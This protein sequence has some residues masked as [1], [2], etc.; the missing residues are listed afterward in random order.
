MSA[1][2]AA[3]LAYAQRLNWPV[4][5]IHSVNTAG[6]C[7]CAKADCK[8]PGKHPMGH[9]APNGLKD[10]TLD[11]D[12]ITRWWS[13]MPNANIGIVT[14]AVSEL[15]VLDV[16][17]QKYGEDSLYTLTQEFGPLPETVVALTGGGGAH[18]LFQHP[19][20]GI[21]VRNSVENL[22]PGLDIRGD[23]GYI[24]VSPSRHAS[25]RTY[26]WE[27]SCRPLEVPVAPLPDWLLARII[28]HPRP[29]PAPAVG[30][31]GSGK[32]YPGEI[33]RLKAA[34]TFLDPDAYDVWIQTGM[35]LH[36]SGDD[37]RAFELWT[38]WAAQS[39]KFDL[40][41][42]QRRWAGFSR[43]GNGVGLGT[44]FAS[45]KAAGYAPPTPPPYEPP[46][47]PPTPPGGDYAGGSGADWERCLRR[48]GKGRVESTAGNIETIL[49]NHELWAG[50]L[51]YDEMSYST[52]K[53]RP[54]PYAG[55]KAGEWTDADDIWTAIWLE[56]HYDVCPRPT[57]VGQVVAATAQ[58]TPF[59]QVRRWLE[60]LTPWDGIDRLPRF[61]VDA[62]G[63]TLS[64]YVEA[65]GRAF[66]V[67]AVARV[68][69]PGVKVDT[70][71]TLE[72]K[73]GVGK[74]KLILELFSPT[75]HIEISY[76][77][78]SVDF[79]QSL[80]GCWCA[81]FGELS[82]FDKAD[83]NRIKQVL[84]QVQ[85]TYRASY[86]RHAGTYPRQVVFVGSTNKKEWGFDE[87]GMR[88]F[89]PIYC[90]E[91][92]VEYVKDNREQLWAEA[93]QRFNAG[94]TWWD[95]P[96]A[97]REQD[98]RFDYDAWEELVANWLEI[99]ERQSLPGTPFHFGINEVYEKAIHGDNARNIPPI[100]RGDQ[101]RLG[102]VL[103]RLGWQ[104]KRASGGKREYLYERAPT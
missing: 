42:H 99:R 28:D 72:G 73:Q 4:L 85:D 17:S 71:L 78:G 54:P 15:A 51:A 12:T 13:A 45:A 62:C 59:H 25:G 94:E 41:D 57:T 74:S 63:A 29:V 53:L 91:I 68:M 32:L 89:L 21:K 19:G 95:I 58:L 81:E 92:N 66:F 97:E 26:E 98:A 52:V 2:L 7:S 69:K 34:L 14:G 76:A 70:M 83:T 31:S 1:H 40:A 10:A 88:R 102:R 46:P 35:A 8:R 3:A 100:S 77:P 87:T 93:L 56:K 44:L 86:G 20:Q 16:D 84:T 80:R 49:Q 33:G 6:L 24:I 75:W 48:N 36:S 79:F 18:Y 38:N 5:P 22:G 37:E 43:G 50:L 90:T 39:P 11:P 101:V 104:R 103:T 96:D 82:Q 67:A 64:P 9:L 61:F 23:G 30:G 27:G 47:P 60:Q 65:V 55:G